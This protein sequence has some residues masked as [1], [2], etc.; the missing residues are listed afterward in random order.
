MATWK[1]DH[2]TITD[3]GIEVIN[4]LQ[5]GEEKIKIVSAV[6]GAGRVPFDSLRSL[7]SIPNVKQTLEI[8]DIQYGEES[9]SVDL[10]LS[11]TGLEES[12]QLCM[13]G[14]LATHPSIDGTFLY[15]VAEC[16]EDG[17]EDVIPLPTDTPAS[18]E[19][20]LHIF[21]ANKATVEILVDLSGYTP[22]KLF[23]EHIKD[24]NNP[25]KTSFR[26]LTDFE[27]WEA[28]IQESAKDTE[29]QAEIE[30]LEELIK[31]LEAKLMSDI[32]DNPFAITFETLDG[33]EIGDTTYWNVSEARLEC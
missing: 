20:E 30:R 6:A 8:Q 18:L 32:T 7:T 26:K 1:R 9:S 2:A 24:Y 33:L 31:A 28:L 14:L 11:N 27:E 15:F 17:N 10:Y 29:L 16:E 3:I 25:H 12:Y 21:G 23:D 4:G 22:Q 19:Y 13:L 5:V